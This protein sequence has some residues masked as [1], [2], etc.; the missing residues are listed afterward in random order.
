MTPLTATAVAPTGAERKG[1][2]MEMDEALAGLARALGRETVAVRELREA[3]VRQRD[4]VAADAIEAVHGSCDDI[5]RLLVTLDTAKRHRVGLM[6]R[7]VPDGPATLESLAAA[8]GG[9]LPA[10]LAGAG[11]ELRREAAEAAREAAINR[12]V[13][14]RTVEAG[15]A[16]LQALF[17]GAGEKDPVYRA[18]ERRDDDGSGFLLDRTA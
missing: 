17:A 2:N 3:L 7:L 16:F 8:C 15:E 11:L 1:S 6:Q 9:S 14:Q 12:V 5:A 18:G 13:L 4:G 10:D